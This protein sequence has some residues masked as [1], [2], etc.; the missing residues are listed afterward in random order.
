MQ[1]FDIV[2]LILNYSLFVTDVESFFITYKLL[3]GYDLV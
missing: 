1:K 3:Q 2:Q